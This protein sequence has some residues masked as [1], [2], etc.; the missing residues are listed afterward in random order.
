MRQGGVWFKL[1]IDIIYT[2]LGT[3]SLQLTSMNV[4]QNERSITVSQAKQGQ[5]LNWEQV[6]KKE[7]KLERIV[8]NGS[9]WDQIYDRYNV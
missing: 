5:W 1:T 6:E 3:L 2:T 4:S 7:D 8:E 9:Q